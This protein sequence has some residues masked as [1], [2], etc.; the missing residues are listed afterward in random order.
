MSIPFLFQ[1]ISA[2]QFV[3]SG[4]HEKLSWINWEGKKITGEEI[5]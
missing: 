4:A 3:A 5:I 1:F 2:P